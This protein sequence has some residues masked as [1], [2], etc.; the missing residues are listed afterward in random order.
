V[1]ENRATELVTRSISPEISS[2]AGLRSGIAAFI[3]DSFSHGRS[4][5]GDAISRA[6]LLGFA[7]G[8]GLGRLGVSQVNN[9][10][11]DHVESAMASGSVV[12]RTA[13]RRD[14]SHILN[15]VANKTRNC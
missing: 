7:P 5:L 6:I 11:G 10:L 14:R 12:S 2:V 1:I 8:G 15:S 4:V 13:S 9:S 3:E